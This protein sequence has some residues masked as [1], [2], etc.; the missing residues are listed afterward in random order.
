[1]AAL[2]DWLRPGATPPPA[3]GRRRAAAPRL[4]RRALGSLAGVLASLGQTAPRPD[5]AGS[6]ASA[7]AGA[8]LAATL[9]MVATTTLLRTLPALALGLALALA[10]AALGR[11]PARR[12]AAVLGASLLLSVVLALPAT[13]NVVSGGTALLTLWRPRGA[14][15]GP[16][17]LPEAVAVSSAG[18]V[19]A[20][21]LVTRTA[22]CV[23]LTLTLAATTSTAELFRGMRRLGVPQAFVLVLSMV[24]R[25]LAVLVRAAAELHLARLARS[26]SPLGVQGEEAWAAAG[27]GAVFRRARTLAD[28]VTLAMVSRGFAGEVRFLLPRRSGTR[29]WLLV[30]GALLVA[31]MLFLVDRGIS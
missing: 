11:V 7:D 8:K 25:Y 3:T 19:V 21:R 29:G 14:S 13:L 24:E 2:P 6:L 1:V 30:V 15:F 20:G 4:V 27:V 18:L 5:R 22:A 10:L 9:L 12:T 28:G 17:R 23:A 31:A 26:I 16:W